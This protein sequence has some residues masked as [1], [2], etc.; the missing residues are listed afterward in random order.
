M[1]LHLN[2]GN[3][4]QTSF[5]ANHNAKYKHRTKSQTKDGNQ[6]QFEPS[7]SYE[8]VFLRSSLSQEQKKRIFRTFRNKTEPPQS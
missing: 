4:N 8:K 2:K 7:T 5:H 1:K 3:V 6:T